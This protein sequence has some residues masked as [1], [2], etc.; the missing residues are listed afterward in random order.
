MTT[1]S[2]V[3]VLRDELARPHTTPRRLLRALHAAGLEV[4]PAARGPAWMPTTAQ[5]YA[6]V[7]QAADLHMADMNRYEIAERMGRDKRTIDRYLAAAQALGLLAP[8]KDESG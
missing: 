1:R 5:A 6:L 4:R 2:A 7:K 3:A 8:A